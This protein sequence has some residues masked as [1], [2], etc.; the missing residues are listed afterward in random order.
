MAVSATDRA[1][2]RL[3]GDHGSAAAPSAARAAARAEAPSRA[4]ARVAG[5]LF[6]TATVAGLIGTA[7]LL[8]P[9]VGSADYLVRI[10]AHQDR[11]STGMFFELVGAFACTGIAVALYPVVR[12]HN[13]S[14]AL[15]A[16]AFR[17]IEGALYVVGA[18]LLLKL[19]R[20]YGAA[21]DPSS[22]S[23]RT[24][25][26][27]LRTL[28]DQTAITGALAFY[29][30]AAMYYWA[31]YRSRLLPR[32][33]AGWGLAAVALGAVSGLLVVF[34]V[35]GFM[36]PPQVALNVPIGVNEIVLAIWLI[37]RG[38][39]PGRVAGEGSSSAPR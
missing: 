33:L 13:G 34:R 12:R 26:A 25:G 23:F 18:L 7:L 4:I 37:V 35:T 16:V 36:S 5:V 14:L 3:T 1:E 15:G 9:L 28:R 38:F 20:E 27:L 31:F 8:R 11:V 30:G 24:T 22:A 29:L 39:N 21:A 19:S 17:T 6:I 32:W 2:I 10:S